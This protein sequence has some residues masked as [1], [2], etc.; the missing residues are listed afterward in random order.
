MR[1]ELLQYCEVVRSRHGYCD[2]YPKVIEGMIVH[3]YSKETIQMFQRDG[4]KLAHP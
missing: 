2:A 1:I 4:K 3:P